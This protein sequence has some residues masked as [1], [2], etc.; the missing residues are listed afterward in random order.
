MLFEIFFVSQCFA[1]TF[2]K[3]PFSDF[4]KI[5]NFL[6][7]NVLQLKDFIQTL[8]NILQKHIET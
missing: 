7:Y 2:R 4:L 5:Y 6:I 3:M 8:F 1:I